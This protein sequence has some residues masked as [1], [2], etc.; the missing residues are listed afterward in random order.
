MPGPPTPVQT[1][2]INAPGA[3]TGVQYRL[4]L[5]RDTVWDIVR[6]WVVCSDVRFLTQAN[7][8][9]TPGPPGATG[10]IGYGGL[11]KSRFTKEAEIATW[12]YFEQRKRFV[13][14]Q[15]YIR[16]G[17]GEFVLAVSNCSGQPNTGLV[18]GVDVIE[19]RT[20]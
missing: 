9:G 20:S 12:S 4:D 6:C 8:N 14:F 16:V 1:Y 11:Y 3:G 18:Y 2:E 13:D 5:P 15:Q 17:L 7:Y 19:Y 10:V